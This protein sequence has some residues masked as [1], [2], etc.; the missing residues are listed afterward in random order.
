MATESMELISVCPELV[1]WKLFDLNPNLCNLPMS[2]A[3]KQTANFKC[4]NCHLIKMFKISSKLTLSSN[5]SYHV[6]G[7]RRCGY[8]LG[9]TII[10]GKNNIIAVCPT[11]IDWGLL[12]LNPNESF[13][14]ISVGSC[15]KIN[16]ECPNCHYKST[17]TINKKVKKIHGKYI[18]VGCQKCGYG[19]SKSVYCGVNDVLTLC[20]DI[21]NWKV[22]EL[23]PDIDLA[24]VSPNS[25][26]NLVFECPCCHK[27][28]NCK[29]C[30]KIKKYDNS[31]NIA[32]CVTCGY[33]M[34]RSVSPG[35]T[36]ILTLCPELQSWNAV[37]LN[38][39]LNLQLIR[40][41]SPSQL[42]LECPSCHSVFIRGVFNVIY[43]DD[44]VYRV[45]GCPICGYHM[46]RGVYAGKNDIFTT[47]P[48]LLSEWDYVANYGICTPTEVSAA[49]HIAVYWI[50]RHDKNHKYRMIINQKIRYDDRG[51]ESC[52]YCR[53]FSPSKT[54]LL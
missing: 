50:C 34:R 21:Y 53:G 4:P 47:H 31:Y 9:R 43:I 26:K 49:S 13:K 14:Y 23:N 33:G 1:S 15:K 11:L 8:G 6:K 3:I 35:K 5:G 28:D 24:F 45:R 46:Q 12:E 16:L 30:D 42:S 44:G 52:P 27:V 36:D 38:P 41:T 25:A 2:E 18:I 29:P 54:L 37:E 51:I 22:P 20:K 7:C 48:Y 10:P 19:T 32:G 17:S 39:N 40:A